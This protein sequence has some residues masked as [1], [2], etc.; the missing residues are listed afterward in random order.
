MGAVASWRW[1]HAV[2]GVLFVIGGIAAL[3]SPF[4][5][6]TILASLVGFFLILKGTFDFVIALAVRHDIDLWWM[7]LI[8]GIIE[9]TLGIWA[10]G[11]PGRSAALLIIWVGIGAIIRGIAEIVT[12]V[13]RAQ[14]SRGGHSM[15]ARFIVVSAMVVTSAFGLASCSTQARAER[16]GKEA[17][18][19]ICKAKNANNANEAQ[20]HVNR[21]NDKIN[22]LAR[23][24][25]RDVREDV[26]DLDRNLNQMARGNATQQDVSKIIRSV[27]DARSSARG[28]ASRA[29]TGCSK[30][31]PTAT[32]AGDERDGSRCLNRRCHSANLRGDHAAFIGRFGPGPATSDARATA[33][34]FRTSAASASERSRCAGMNV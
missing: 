3:M 8:A 17:G 6:F 2:L 12:V 24:T 14:A 5:T 18:D 23:F 27:E 22:D 1:V 19:E 26:R 9:I 11:Y 33:P 20:R 13:P 25:G 15:K 29:T 34:R 7:S 30:R 16:K 28:N 31:S 10:M 32:N 21:A 4:Q